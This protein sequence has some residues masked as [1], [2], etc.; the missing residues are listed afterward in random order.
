MLARPGG[1]R[2]APQVAFRI[3]ADLAPVA[4][5]SFD[6][7]LEQVLAGLPVPGHDDRRAQQRLAA[8]GE[9]GL[10]LGDGWWVSGHPRHSSLFAI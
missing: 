1:T 9:E 3:V 4:E 6:S 2:A 10:E 7:R 8:F 5:Q